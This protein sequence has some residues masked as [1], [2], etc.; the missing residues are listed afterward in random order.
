[1]HEVRSHVL[2]SLTVVTDLRRA[3]TSTATSARKVP[4]SATSI[5]RKVAAG[6]TLSGEAKKQ[7]TDPNS[8]RT[9]TSKVQGF[10][11]V[12]HRRSSSLDMN[13]KSNDCSSVETC[14]ASLDGQG[15][16]AV[17]RKRWV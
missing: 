4:T 2:R 8:P 16:S 3:V 1:M 11:A 9:S 7:A 17:K 5:P 14:G 13:F 12:N 10:V 15:T 6:R